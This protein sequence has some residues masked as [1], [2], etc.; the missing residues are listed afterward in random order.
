M[1]IR[2][3]LKVVS[4]LNL[5]LISSAFLT[6][7]IQR[8]SHAQISMSLNIP[9]EVPPVGFFDPLNLSQ[10]RSGAEIK[11]WRESELKHGRIASNPPIL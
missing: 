4:V 9:G 7:S 10:G 8:G 11:K 2:I 5:L 3:S 6:G 1:Q